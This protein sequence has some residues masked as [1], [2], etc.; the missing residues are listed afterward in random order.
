M[1]RFAEKQELI[2]RRRAD[3][4]SRYPAL[5]SNMIA[6]WNSSGTDDRAWLM[7]SAN[8]LFRTGNLRWALDPLTLSWRIKG[9]PEVD[10]VRDLRGLS[11]VLLT[12]RH[13][14]HLD[15]HL[16]SALRSLPITWVI[17][18]FLVPAVTRKAGLL[19]ENILVASPLKLIELSGVRILPFNGLHWE[20]TPDGDQRGVPAM[21]YLVEF[22]GKRWLFPG[23]TRTYDVSQLPNFGPVD[24]LFAHLWLGRSCALKEE[25]PLLEAFC[26]F[27]LDLKPRQIVLSHL[28][29]LGRDANDL[30]D[31]SHIQKTIFRFQTLAPGVPVLPAQMGESILL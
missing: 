1:D 8:Y 24:Y 30:W 13:A 19:H 12:H 27:C 7:Y 26:R 4:C 21:G 11:F 15:I 6:E 25:P 3:I 28:N 14:D 31:D 18:E 2:D 23:D 16:L 29:E 9:S 10:V 20:A 17:P 22:N 5:W